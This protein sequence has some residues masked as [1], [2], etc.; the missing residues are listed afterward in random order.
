MPK[1]NLSWLSQPEMPLYLVRKLP[2]VCV[3]VCMNVRGEVYADCL[4]LGMMHVSLRGIINSNPLR[5]LGL[6]SSELWI[7]SFWGFRFKWDLNFLLIKSLLDGPGKFGNLFCLLSLSYF[8]RAVEEWRQFH[9]DLNDLTHWIT[10]AEELLAGTFAPDGGL[11]LEKARIHQQVSAFCKRLGMCWKLGLFSM[12][13]LRQV[14]KGGAYS[15]NFSGVYRQSVIFVPVL[16]FSFKSLR[17]KVFQF[18]LGI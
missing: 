5:K 16:V 6:Q 8:D 12:H 11:D 14:L 9:C 13:H 2:N 18:K 1:A 4:T 15:I 3:S 17:K 7:H 10:E